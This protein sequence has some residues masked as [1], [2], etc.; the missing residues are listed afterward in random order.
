MI[1]MTHQSRLVLAATSRIVIAA[2][3]RAL[4]RQ[5]AFGKMPLSTRGYCGIDDFIDPGLKKENRKEK[6][7]R[8]SG[9]DK[10]LP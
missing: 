5:L 3:E 9:S 4:L 10:L 6:R 8:R 1:S 7:S 2:T